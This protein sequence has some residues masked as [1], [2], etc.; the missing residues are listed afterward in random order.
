MP[1]SPEK[2]LRLR[3]SASTSSP[4]KHMSQVSCSGLLSS[5]QHSRVGSRS[6][7]I[8]KL[9]PVC[10]HRGTVSERGSW[11]AALDNVR[12]RVATTHSKKWVQWSLRCRAN[13]ARWTQS[14]SLREELFEDLRSAWNTMETGMGVAVEKS[15]DIEHTAWNG[16]RR[17]VVGQLEDTVYR[18][19]GQDR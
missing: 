11:Q 10:I 16:Q 8:S 15:T 17:G 18:D 12:T 14:S 6:D 19:G 1:P 5:F 4:C 3:R 9:V 7:T 13:S 2:A